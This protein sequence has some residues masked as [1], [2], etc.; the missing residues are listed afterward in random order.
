MNIEKP[1]FEGPVFETQGQPGIN[2]I[3]DGLKPS[4][5]L[6]DR[7]ADR[8]PGPGAHWDVNTIVR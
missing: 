3:P 2:L 5:G 1:D 8:Y 7:C 6:I 4:L